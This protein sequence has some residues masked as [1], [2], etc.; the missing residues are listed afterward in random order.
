[1]NAPHFDVLIAG[2]GPAGIAAAVAAAQSGARVGLIDENPAAGGQIWRRGVHPAHTSQSRR[3][4]RRL[5]A[6][7]LTVLSRTKIIAQPE[8]GVV[9]VET[10]DGPRTVR[11]ERIILA[12]GARELFLP[13]PGWTLPGVMGAGGLQALVKGGLPIA[14]RRVVVAGSGPLLLAVAAYL[15]RAGA[16]M[17][18]VAEQSTRAQLL[19]FA[20]RVLSDPAKL[21][22]AAQLGWTLRGVPF[23]T[24]CWVARAHGT[25]RLESVTLHRGRTS[26]VVRCN[27][28]AC[29]FGLVPNL[30][31]PSAFGCASSDGV[32]RVDRW[33]RTSVEGVYCA[34]EATGIG[35]LDAALVE[36]CIAGYAAVGQYGAAQRLMPARARAH[37]FADVL[38]RSFTLR[39]E[40]RAM[41]SDDTIVC[42]CEDVPYGEVRQYRS[43]RSAKLQTRCGM[44]PCQGRVCGAATGFLFGWTQDSFRPPVVAARIGSLTHIGGLAEG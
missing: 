31:L 6:D 26:T 11:Y 24:G 21:A 12:T 41:A 14:G 44:G 9:L 35:G 36:G 27:Y 23:R 16:Q 19:P 38:A 33:Q 13:F 29:G 30:D 7:T 18:V 22:Q 32:V 15:R 8:R 34:G 25:E 3:W 40:L 2:A 5:R 1:M 42:R 28:L 4:L 37:R 20:L 10:D 17:V 39:S 43:W